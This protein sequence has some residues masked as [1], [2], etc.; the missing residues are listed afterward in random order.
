MKR[1]NARYD[2]AF[3]TIVNIKSILGKNK[4]N[5]KATKQKKK[6]P[7]RKEKTKKTKNKRCCH[8]PRL[9]NLNKI[10]I[11]CEINRLTIK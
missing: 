2:Y 8:Y 6:K 5:K 3:F 1:V 10:S 7:K 4:T 11:G 9:K